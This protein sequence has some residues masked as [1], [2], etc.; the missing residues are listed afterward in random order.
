MH[1]QVVDAVWR[2]NRMARNPAMRAPSTSS[3]KLS[4]ICKMWSGGSLN[5]RAAT[6]NIFP[7]GLVKPASQETVMTSNGS[8]RPSRSRSGRRRSS[9]L[10]MT[11]NLNPRTARAS[12]AGG[13]PQ[14][15]ARPTAAQSVRRVRQRTSG[16]AVPPTGR[17]CLVHHRRP[18]LP[19][20]VE[21]LPSMPCSDEP[22][23]KLLR[24]DLLNP[25]PGCNFRVDVT[26]RRPRF[27]QRSPD[28]ERHR[29]D[30]RS[31]E[32]PAVAAWGVPPHSFSARSLPPASELSPSNTIASPTR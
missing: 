20:V 14:K 32:R 13:H 22:V 16:S 6:S 24:L 18:F 25:M 26:D 2:N 15:S 28:I 10:E 17:E 23:V 29:L 5:P 1:S 3:R 9:Q 11:P 30:A 19:R 8:A 4:P 21:T 31:H 27:D 12:R 7:S